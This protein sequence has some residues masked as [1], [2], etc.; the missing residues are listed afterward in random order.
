[1]EFSKIIMEGPPSD[2]ESQAS[3]LQGD[4]CG[5]EPS[6]LKSQLSAIATRGC[7]SCIDHA[8]HASERQS[9]VEGG[10]AAKDF[11]PGS[12]IESG[13]QNNTVLARYD[14]NTIPQSS[15]ATTTMAIEVPCPKDESS[16]RTLNF[17]Q[18]DPHNDIQKMVNSADTSGQLY[19]SS[20]LDE[21]DRIKGA[22]TKDADVRQELSKQKEI[23]GIPID[24]TGRITAPL[25]PEP[26]ITKK[27]KAR[28]QALK[29]KSKSQKT[30]RYTRKIVLRRSVLSIALGRQLADVTYNSLKIIASARS[31]TAGIAN[32]APTPVSIPAVKPDS[33]PLGV[34][35]SMTPLTA[36]P[37]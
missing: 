33:K 22:A 2:E 12:Q 5:L 24:Q 18:N 34:V 17:S 1:V 25:T 27:E 10:P 13:L 19:I 28:I 14:G 31:N 15:R 23:P 11:A 9:F 21:G 6:D 20:L 16:S 8:R 3:I 37:V 36:L 26:N 30:M 29:V 7:S 35:T 4:P 32:L